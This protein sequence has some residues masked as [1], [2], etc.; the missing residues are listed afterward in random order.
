[1]DDSW[2][3][4]SCYDVLTKI[5]RLF[6]AVMWQEEGIY[7]I[8]RISDLVD[9]HNYRIYSNPKILS[10]YGAEDLRSDF[11][12]YNQINRSAILM[13]S[14]IYKQLNFG[15]DLS[16][17]N[18]INNGTV[19]DLTPDPLDYWNVSSGNGIIDYVNWEYT[20]TVIST[21]SELRSTNYLKIVSGT[22]R[23]TITHENS[24]RVYNGTSFTFNWKIDGDSASGLSLGLI[25][26]IVR[27][28]VGTTYYLDLTT[29]DWISSSANSYIAL[30]SGNW[31]QTG[32]IET[33]GIP[34]IVTSVWDMY[35]DV[36][37]PNWGTSGK[38]TYVS[39]QL[40]PF[41]ESFVASKT[42]EDL[43]LE[44]NADNLEDSEDIILYFSDVEDYENKDI[45]AG[46]L[47]VASSG[48]ATD[49]WSTISG[50]A[51]KQLQLLCRDC[52]KAQYIKSA[53]RLQGTLK[54]D[55]ILYG[56]VLQDSSDRRYMPV[57]LTKN[58]RESE[59]QG[60]WIEIKQGLEAAETLSFTNNAGVYAFDTFTDNG[61]GTFRGGYV[62][63]G[64]SL[65]DC[66]CT[67]N[68]ITSGLDKP[69]KITVSIFDNRTIPPVQTIHFYW[70]GY[71]LVVDGS[72]IDVTGTASDP[73]IRLIV[74]PG[75]TVDYVIGITIQEI[76]GL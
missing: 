37:E 60:E 63:S 51:S 68:G 53:R 41:G 44:L 19:G 6:N 7:K 14:P 18:L 11:S 27:P 38:D 25:V 39:L 31:E 72:I 46:A 48:D 47:T 55:G 58:F 28:G 23:T 20:Y 73:E 3:S 75:E 32:S 13:S 4:I 1:M 69:Y 56:E 50:S 26:R 33:F 66:R 49:S 16:R 24:Y 52:Y 65:A 30:T 36:V 54:K 74:Q 21:S 62:N 5:L 70:G 42:T 64:P 22:S 43:T 45:L 35:I 8:K 67:I 17:K 57:S 2:D 40:I 12:D 9:S 76:Y 34:T 59:L 29:G 15:V 61:D 10:S 71:N